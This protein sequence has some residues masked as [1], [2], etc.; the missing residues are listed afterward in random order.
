MTMKYH[1]RLRADRKL[2]KAIRRHRA[3]DAKVKAIAE[4]CKAASRAQWLK[5]AEDIEVLFWRMPS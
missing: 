5:A 3:F 4:G 1:A 2:R